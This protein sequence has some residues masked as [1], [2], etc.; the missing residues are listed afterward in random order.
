[1]KNTILNKLEDKLPEFGYQLSREPFSKDENSYQLIVNLDEDLDLKL[2][3][4]LLGDLLSI[5]ATQ[6]GIGE[7]SREFSENQVD[8]LQLF[9]QFPFDFQTDVVPDMAR[10]ILMANWSTPI[11]SFGMNELQKLLYYR[12]VFECVGDEPGENV[13]VEAVNAMAFYSKLRYESLSLIANAEITLDEYLKNLKE[14]NRWS[15]EFPGYD[16]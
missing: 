3:I 10:L 6:E 2:S 14:E 16:L 1:M 11:G 4:F 5:A 7:I 8:F 13:V 9:I 12:Q 15:E